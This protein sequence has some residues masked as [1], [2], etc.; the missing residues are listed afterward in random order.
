MVP[1]AHLASFALPT[2]LH[3]AKRSH[4][5]HGPAYTCAAV[6]ND[7]DKKQT[8]E[9]HQSVDLA[10]PMISSDDEVEG[11]L[12]PVGCSFEP[13]SALAPKTTTSLSSDGTTS[14]TLFR[15]LSLGGR[16][17]DLG[18]LKPKGTASGRFSFGPKAASSAS[19]GGAW[20]EGATEMRNAR[21]AGRSGDG[22]G[23]PAPP[24]GAGRAGSGLLAGLVAAGPG[25]RPRGVVLGMGSGAAALGAGSASGAEAAG[26]PLPPSEGTLLT[27]ERLSGCMRGVRE[28][29]SRGVLTASGTS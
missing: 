12:P 1:S 10:L 5:L 2:L 9:A 4:L 20:S 8:H 17:V 19:G 7:G 14:A 25:V 16:P 23:S 28:P 11:L 26:P 24:G 13:P 6:E 27:L 18:G 3:I 29:G 15:R 22:G 21:G